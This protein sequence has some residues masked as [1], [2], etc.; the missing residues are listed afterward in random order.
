MPH[1]RH[2]RLCSL[3]CVAVLAIACGPEAALP[4]ALG[5]VDAAGSSGD[6]VPPP[7]ASIPRGP[8]KLAKKI[9]KNEVRL[10]RDVKKWR[11]NGA[12]R[13]AGLVPE[14][15]LRALFQQRATRV[16]VKQRRL[17]NKVLWRLKPV[18]KWFF[19]ANVRAARILSH[20]TGTPPEKPP[21][22]RYEKSEPP[23]DLKRYYG[24]AKKRFRVPVNILASVNFVE[25]KFGRILGPSSAGAKGPMQFLPSTWEAYGLAGN[26]WDPHDAIFGAGNYLSASGAPERMYDAL[27]AYNPSDAYVKTVQAYA[28]Q[29]RRHPFRYYNYY[30]WQ[31]FI[32]TQDGVIQMTGPGTSRPKY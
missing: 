3:A 19:K 32:K 15:K 10:V 1:Q 27:H 7:D 30:W 11:R 13:G 6:W 20:L 2:V 5:P 28:R 31:V 24:A 26:I 12:L 4:S 17:Y 14:I 23:N 8:Y 25:T 29:M 18:A 9:N 16:L 21:E 22:M